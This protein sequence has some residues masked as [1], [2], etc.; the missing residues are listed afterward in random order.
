MTMVS[1][2]KIWSERGQE[3]MARLD[4]PMSTIPAT[5]FPKDGSNMKC[6]QLATL[7]ALFDLPH[8]GQVLNTVWNRIDIVVVERN[9]IAHGSLSPADVGSR[10]SSQEIRDQVAAWFA[11]WDAFVVD[12][13]ARLGPAFFKR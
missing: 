7:C 4:S 10:Y 3:L 12:I 8:P 2:H 9:G 13:D 1:Q 11:A 5:V 6:G